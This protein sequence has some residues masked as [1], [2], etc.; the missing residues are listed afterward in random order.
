MR[1]EQKG[2]VPAIARVAAI[3]CAGNSKWLVAYIGGYKADIVDCGKELAW[4]EA[5]TQIT[6]Y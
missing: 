1:R 5:T 3:G 6:V 4:H 2:V